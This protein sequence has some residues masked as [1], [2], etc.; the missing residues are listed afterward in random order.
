MSIDKL[1]AEGFLK[2]VQPSAERSKK[3]L[4]ISEKYLLEAK[5]TA[6]INAPHASILGAYNCVFHAARAILFKDGVAERSHF[7]IAD[8]LQEK[9]KDF[10]ADYI[11]SFDH[12]RKLRHSVAYGLDTVVGE[13]DA[14]EA[15]KFAEDFLKKVKAYLK[16]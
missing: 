7:A 1:F 14:K 5:E 12:Y 2:K 13:N 15:V 9:H 10:G 8:Y 6:K 16:Q 4:A 11:A 3:S